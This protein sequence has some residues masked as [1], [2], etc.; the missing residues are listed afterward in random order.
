MAVD[1]AR[2]RFT[3]SEL[4][5]ASGQVLEAAGTRRRPSPA[6][7]AERTVGAF[8]KWGTGVL[9]GRELELRAVVRREVPDANPG[10]VR[11]AVEQVRRADAKVLREAAD[12]L[13]PELRAAFAGRDEDRVRE[14][15]DR[16]RA[17]F[18]R[19]DESAD[20]R[21][22]RAAERAVV[23]ENVARPVP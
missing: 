19:L 14:A 6:T 3:P 1:L 13:E 18:E 4:V 21:V 8:L 22:V 10:S 20:L 17:T 2:V 23:W 16:E 15:L 5:A 11:R 9:S 12:R 7:A